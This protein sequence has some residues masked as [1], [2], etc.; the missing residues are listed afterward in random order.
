MWGLFEALAL[1]GLLAAVVGFVRAVITRP[2][3]SSRDEDF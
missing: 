1:A 3:K 2:R